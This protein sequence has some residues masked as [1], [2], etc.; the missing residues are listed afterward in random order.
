M[1][2]TY[3]AEQIAAERAA[4]GIPDEPEEFHLWIRYEL[5]KRHNAETGGR[6]RQRDVAKR[7]HLS[8][9]TVSHVLQGQRVFGRGSER[10]KRLMA[11]ILEIP[12]AVLFPPRVEVGRKWEPEA[13]GT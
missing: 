3:T 6:W 4:R 5:S 11:E 8:D 1:A 12:L 2:D 10:V 7:T 9:A 13:S